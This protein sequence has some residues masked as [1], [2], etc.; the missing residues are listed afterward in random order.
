MATKIT[1]DTIES[2][3]NCKYK[4]HLKLTGESGAISDYEAMTTA[5]RESSREQALTRLAARFGEGSARWGTA[6]TAD[7]LEQG[8]PIL[9][10]AGLE[11]EDLSV[12]FDAL[13][14]A[15]GISKLGNH[16]YVPVLHNDGEKVGRVQKLLL[17]VLALALARVQGM[18]PADGLVAHGTEA[19]LGTI[20]LD[21]KLY[22]RAE[23]V[24]GELGRL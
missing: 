16:H 8:A 4:G 17:A 11:D 13:K 5:A 19:R 20:R 1:R 18:R 6:A 3:L 9:L 23:Q 10:D 7:L 14:R 22:R 21:P 12:C 24:L 15:D 2:Y